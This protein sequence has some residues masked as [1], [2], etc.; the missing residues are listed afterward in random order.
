MKDQFG[1]YLLRARQGEKIL[2][3]EHGRSVALLTSLGEEAPTERALELVEAGV[4]DWSGGKPTGSKRR[5]ITRG[6]SASE[7]VLEDRR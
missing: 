6:K 2:I 1:S 4:A 3:T 5:P 7:I